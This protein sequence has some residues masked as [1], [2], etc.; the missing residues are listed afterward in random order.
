[1]LLIREERNPHDLPTETLAL[2]L[3]GTQEWIGGTNGLQSSLE[4]LLADARDLHLRRLAPRGFILNLLHG[5]LFW[6][7]NI[8]TIG[9][10]GQCER[11]NLGR[12]HQNDYFSK[13]LANALDAFGGGRHLSER[14]DVNEH[15]VSNETEAGVLCLHSQ[16]L[17]AVPIQLNHKIPPAHNGECVGARNWRAFRFNEECMR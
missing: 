15:A 17:K 7:H 6:K 3:F 13:T 8:L 10:H 4:I 9:E 16:P 1:M 5:K 14:S 2:D 12:N 11:R